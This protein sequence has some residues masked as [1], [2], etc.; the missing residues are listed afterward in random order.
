MK[1]LSTTRKFEKDLQK[2]K[3]SGELVVVLSHLLNGEPLPV[4]NCDHALK[5]NLSG[6]RECHIRPDLLLLYEELD[7]EIRLVRL[8][9]HSELF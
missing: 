7:N 9:S 5:G 6:F 4:K 8:G 3:L 1:R 2:L